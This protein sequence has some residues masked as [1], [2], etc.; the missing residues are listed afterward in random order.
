MSAVSPPM[1]GGKLIRAVESLTVSGDSFKHFRHVNVV[2]ATFWCYRQNRRSVASMISRSIFIYQLDHP[3]FKP[4]GK[5]VQPNYLQFLASNRPYRLSGPYVLP[6]HHEPF[7]S[8]YLSYC[9]A[10]FSAYAKLKDCGEHNIQ[11]LCH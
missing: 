7:Q 9:S 2:S 10:K 11:S 6:D 5:E 3:V 1:A 4:F 8:Q